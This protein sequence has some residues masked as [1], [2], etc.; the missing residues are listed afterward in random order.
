[1]IKEIV[2][3]VTQQLEHEERIVRIFCD[4]YQREHKASCQFIGH[5]DPPNPDAVIR[6]ADEEVRIELA[7]YRENTGFNRAY[8]ND[9]VLKNAIFDRSLQVP[10]LPRC[11]PIL[12][13]RQNGPACYSIPPAAEQ[14]KFIGELFDFLRRYDNVHGNRLIA[15]NFVGESQLVRYQRRANANRSYVADSEYLVLSRYC[16]AVAIHR[17]PTQLFGR[18]G[19][20]MDSRF[21]TVDCKTITKTISGKLNKVLGYRAA[22][23]GKPLW[24]LYYSEGIGPS[25]LPGR[26]HNDEVVQLIRTLCQN[27]PAQFDAVWWADGMYAHGG[28]TVF[29]V[30]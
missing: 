1:V 12:R 24:L 22:I 8:G 9:Q 15:V 27:Q 11:T 19:S 21:L 14:N 17:H 26:N 6:I 10:G 20:S 5:A 4:W 25:H 18:P 23:G 16:R 2:R 28:P 29:R 13:Y 7:R 3:S 30:I